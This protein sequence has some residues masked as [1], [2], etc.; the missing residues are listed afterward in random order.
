MDAWQACLLWKRLAWP[1]PPISTHCQPP[2]PNPPTYPPLP[3]PHSCCS[4]ALPVHLLSAVGMLRHNSTICSGAALAAPAAQQLT[5]W[6]FRV[7]GLLRLSMQPMISASPVGAPPDKECAGLLG[8][9][10]LSLGLAAPAVV[11]LSQQV[12]MFMQHQRERLQQ[13]MPAE[14]GWNAR[15]YGWL[16][17][18]CEAAQL[19]GVL[20]CLWAAALA[21]ELA[22][23]VA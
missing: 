3:T 4:L 18:M 22:L 7:L 6:L 10:Q 16:G 15:L 5:S 23:L 14:S 13:G 21:W 20:P 12:R 11:A 19:G 2:L 17:C 9:L 1:T 8:F